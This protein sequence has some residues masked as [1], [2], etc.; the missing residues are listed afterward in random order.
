MAAW[1]ALRLEA[2]TGLEPEGSKRTISFWRTAMGNKITLKTAMGTTELVEHLTGLIDGLK[3]G[4]IMIEQGTDFIVLYVSDKVDFRLETRVKSDKAKLKMSLAWP[5]ELAEG[6]P[7]TLCIS[8]GLSSAG[9]S[10]D[11]A[12]SPTAKSGETSAEDVR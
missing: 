3:H 5:L 4:R 1:S 6:E 8:D 11:A 10:R 12:P 9:A 2:L 7:S